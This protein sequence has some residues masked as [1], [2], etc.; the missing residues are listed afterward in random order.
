MKELWKKYDEVELT[1]SSVH[2]LMA[3]HELLKKNGYVR[4]VDVANHLNISRSSV[5]ITLKKLK[6]KGYISEDENRFFHF[7]E[8]GQEL[9]NG[10]LSKRRIIQMFF[11][12]VLNLSDVL[13]EEEAC[14]IEH[15]LDEQ[16]GQKLMS[17]MGFYMSNE[18]AADEFRKK[19]KDFTFKCQTTETCDICELNCYMAGSNFNEFI[20]ANNQ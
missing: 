3:M 20:N 18:T 14:K 8:H 7:T 12:N 19:F 11:K 6:L 16:T 1:Q 9:I 10:V 2:H 17:F 13:A 15:L 4:G 5:S